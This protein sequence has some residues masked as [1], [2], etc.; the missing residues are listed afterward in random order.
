[1]VLEQPLTG[2]PLLQAAVLSFPLTFF[3]NGVNDVY[4][5]EAD[6]LDGLR[7]EGETV[8]DRF[9]DMRRYRLALVAAAAMVMASTV[10]F[11][12]WNAVFVAGM[13]ALG[14][15]YSAP[16][17]RLKE[18]PPFD[19]LS[20]G[21]IAVFFSFYA[22]ASTFTSPLDVGFQH[23]LEALALTLAV[24]AGHA[25]YAAI[26]Y[27]PDS[28]AGLTT[29]ATVYGKRFC[30]ASAFTAVVLNYAVFRSQLGVYFD[31]VVFYMLAVLGSVLV[32]R[33]DA[34]YMLR[35]AHAIYP[36]F[37]VA[38]LLFVALDSEGLRISVELLDMDLRIP[39]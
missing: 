3:I 10:L 21:F 4:D 13:L 24:A 8:R 12:F 35:A 26:D 6:E 33:D 22:G 28:E 36:A 31:V 16:P 18:R 29:V 19:S 17:V 15:L 32:W 39:G 27:E 37:V 25:Y 2:P 20:N 7:K 34:E 14:Y 30:V 38:V 11:G 23:S 5:V 9:D 1:M